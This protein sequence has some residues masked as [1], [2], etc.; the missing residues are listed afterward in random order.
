[1]LVQHFGV[2]PAHPSWDPIFDLDGDGVTISV[3]DIIA[4]VLQFG[5]TCE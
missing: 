3:T 5:I 2:T 1:L 4:A